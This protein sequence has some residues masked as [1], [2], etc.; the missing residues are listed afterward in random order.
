MDGVAESWLGTPESTEKRR[1]PIAQDG[2]RYNAM[3]LSEL[4]HFG[5]QIGAFYRRPGRSNVKAMSPTAK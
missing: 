2:S 4:E 3:D 5:P 1:F